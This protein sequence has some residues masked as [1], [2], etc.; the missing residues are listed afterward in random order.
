MSN[1]AV[2]ANEIADGPRV[3]KKIM[4]RLI[5]FLCLLFIVNYL[6]RTNVAMAKL[7]MLG[8]AHLT[9]G[10]YGL[11]AGL[12][13]IGYFLFEVPSNLILQRIGAR[14]WIARIMISWGILSAMMMFVRGT[15]SFYGLRFALG[16][17]E[18]GFFPG[19]VFYL[20]AWAPAA[21]RSQ[22]LAIFLTS[23]ALSGVVGTPL[24]GWIMQMEGIAGLHGWQWLFLLEGL[25]AVGLG[26][27]ILVSGLL[28]D[29]PANA[30]W[31]TPGER[32]WI[33]EELAR[34]HSQ[35]HVNHIADLRA[36][37]GDKR[38]WLFSGIYFTLIMGLY[39]FI[40]WVP[41]IVKSLT[42]ADN[43]NVG[44]ISA[45]PYLIAAISMVAIGAVA[46]YT[47]RRRWSVSICAIIGSGGIVALCASDRP[48]IGMASLCVAAIG[49]F[50]TLGPFWALPS[51][52]LRDTAAAG[53]IAVVNSTGALAGFVAPGVIGWAKEA[54]GRFTAGLLVVAGSLLVGSILILLVPGS[55]EGNALGKPGR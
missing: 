31:L 44:L 40:Y 29:S 43:V 18:A 7:Q 24:A 6:D 14:R 3:V 37:V 11:G 16:V 26:I 54:T 52:Y 19:I 55:V 41:T 28:P 46:D 35:S 15:A 30:K 5:P 17:A 23:T 27:A 47:G 8:D 21:R 2:D 9:D 51:R 32:I 42:H 45:I 34:D 22:L 25:P 53:G 48:I 20:T 1:I 12:F 33:E 4:R 49:I 39:G 50:G 38:L 10:S 36:A 13:F